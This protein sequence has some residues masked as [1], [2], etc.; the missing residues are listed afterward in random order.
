LSTDLFAR[1]IMP[2]AIGKFGMPMAES[3]ADSSQ[4]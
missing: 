2:G 1:G 3:M 4:A